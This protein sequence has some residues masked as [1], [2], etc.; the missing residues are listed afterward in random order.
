MKEQ[1]REIIIFQSWIQYINY[2]HLIVPTPKGPSYA[3]LRHPNTGGRLNR[4][5]IKEGQKYLNSKIQA[6]RHYNAR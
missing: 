1:K 3:H 6:C 5:F 4:T 2:K